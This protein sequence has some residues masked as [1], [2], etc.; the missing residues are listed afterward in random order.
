MCSSLYGVKDLIRGRFFKTI[1]AKFRYVVIPLALVAF[2]FKDVVHFIES[3][4]EYEFS[5]W[6]FFCLGASLECGACFLESHGHARLRW[7]IPEMK[8]RLISYREVDIA[9]RRLDLG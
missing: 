3:E 1:E 8:H 6:F 9:R 7:M 4:L 5:R 2:V